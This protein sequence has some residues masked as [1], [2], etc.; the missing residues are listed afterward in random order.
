MLLK[1]AF[2][3]HS[4]YGHMRPARRARVDQLLTAPH[5]H[6]ST[7]RDA[8]T[9]RREPHLA[10]LDARRRHDPLRHVVHDL[11]RLLEA[12]IVALVKG[13]R[14]QPCISA[15]QGFITPSAPG[16]ASRI[17]THALM[18]SH[19][20]RKA[21]PNMHVSQVWLSSTCLPAAP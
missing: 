7:P 3:P 16:P 12:R 4:K 20:S 15:E 13:E 11:V 9:A 2:A 17:A 19:V 8:G 21:C 1:A 5:G 6:T 10:R 14:A 18:Q